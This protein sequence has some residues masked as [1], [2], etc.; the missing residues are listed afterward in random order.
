MKSQAGIVVLCSS[1]DT[2]GTMAL[3]VVKAL[4]DHSVIVVAGYPEDDL[5]DLQLAG[6]EHFIHIRSNMLETLQ[7]FNKLL[8]VE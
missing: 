6:I 5:E 1:D 7:Q 8:L 4:K 2:Y 3:P